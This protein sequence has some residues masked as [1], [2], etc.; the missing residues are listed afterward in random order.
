MSCNAVLCRET[1]CPVAV[2]SQDCYVAGDSLEPLSFLF[3]PVL[4]LEAGATTVCLYGT[5][6][7][8]PGL[9]VC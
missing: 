4:G 8:N 1:K 3:L 2:S 5:G 9:D 6:E 7:L